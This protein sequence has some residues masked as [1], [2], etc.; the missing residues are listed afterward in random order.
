[1][2][3]VAE[4]VLLKAIDRKLPEVNLVSLKL[5]RIPNLEALAPE[6]TQ[7]MVVNLAKN[8]LFDGD[9]VFLVSSP[10]LFLWFF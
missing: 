6:L 10:L 8:N 2:Q 3:D 1:L 5:R 7:L 4:R 9:S